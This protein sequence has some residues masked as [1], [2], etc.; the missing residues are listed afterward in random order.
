ML[1]ELRLAKLNCFR[2]K[3]MIFPNRWQRRNK[4]SNI[5][6]YLGSSSNGTPHCIWKQLQLVLRSKSDF[7]CQCWSPPCS[8]LHC[9]EKQDALCA[10]APAFACV[11]SG[12]RWTVL[13]GYSNPGAIIL[14]AEVMQAWATF[15][16][17]QKMPSHHSFYLCSHVR[18]Q[19]NR[20]WGGG[21][22]ADITL[23][24]IPLPSVKP[25]STITAI[26]TQWMFL[27]K[28]IIN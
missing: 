18:A 12:S 28:F 25:W 15:A 13:W 21:G 10:Q 3:L 11:S 4:V 1:V 27:A 24:N 5:L 22:T 17:R 2:A 26:F 9:R 8:G 20:F 14:R 6:Q 23:G 7:L 19:E 16:D